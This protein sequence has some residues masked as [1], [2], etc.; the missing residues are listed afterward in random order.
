MN[1]LAGPRFTVAATMAQSPA[2]GIGPIV[3]RPGESNHASSSPICSTAR[4]PTCR[5]IP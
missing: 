3:E 1:G 5:P 4:S 2:A